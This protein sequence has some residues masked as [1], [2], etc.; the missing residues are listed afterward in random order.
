L[1]LIVKNLVTNALKFTSAGHVTVSVSW[2]GES[3]ELN[4]KDTGSGMAPE[5]LPLI[6]QPFWQEDTSSI[7]RHRG[8]GLGLYI[9]QQLVE[10]LGGKL[11]VTSE[12]GKGSTFRVI[13]PIAARQEQP[14]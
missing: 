14:P 5:V 12:V 9:V 1:K 10:V 7:R 13:L 4:V 11:V 8:V 6:F 2:Q 3:V